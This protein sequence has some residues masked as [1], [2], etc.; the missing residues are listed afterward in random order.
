MPW[1]RPEQ[2]VKLLQGYDKP[3]T[4]NKGRCGATIPEK[5]KLAGGLSHVARGSV[6]SI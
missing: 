2:V 3:L 5:K 6:T 4:Q 1:C